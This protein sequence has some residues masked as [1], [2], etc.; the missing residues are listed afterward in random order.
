MLAVLE[1]GF[2]SNHVWAVSRRVCGQI[3]VHLKVYT[4][5]CI[6][7]HTQIRTFAIRVKLKTHKKCLYFEDYTHL[8]SI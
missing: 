6:I 7:S 4:H 5:A 1:I 3:L 8:C 2:P